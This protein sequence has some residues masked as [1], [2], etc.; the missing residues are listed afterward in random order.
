MH[1]HLMKSFL[2][3]LIVL[4]L[5]APCSYAA[6]AVYTADDGYASASKIS[7]EYHDSSLYTVDTQIGFATDIVLHPGESLVGI[8]AGD[9]KQW[10]IDKA[11]VGGT[12]HVY[13]KPLVPNVTTDMIIN[14]DKHSYR[15]LVNS[16]DTYNP[17][18]SFDFVEEMYQQLAKTTVYK[19]RA[20]KEYLDIYTEQKDGHF[21]PKKMHYGYT[22]KSSNK[23]LTD[24]LLPVK[25]FDDGV[26]TYIQMPPQNRYDLPV[27]YNVDPS[28][29]K[30]LTLVNYRVKGDFYIA[31]RVFNHARLQYSSKLFIDIYPKKTNGGDLRNVL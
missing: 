3:T 11:M 24:D 20:E 13:I 4:N 25:I 1:K 22:V 23:D 30:K 29:N 10:A 7:Y 27:L 14:T 18:I 15:L 5:S 28:D 6:K 8:I 9:T 2:A 12:C 17:V 21:I 16:T 31:D 26:R 19:D